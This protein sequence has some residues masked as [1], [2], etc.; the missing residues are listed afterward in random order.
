MDLSFEKFDQE[1]HYETVCDWW[2]AHKWP[3]VRPDVLSD[4]GIVITS[5]GAP[6][7]A[8]W[9][10]RSNSSVCWL[11]FFVVNPKIEKN[12]RDVCLDLMIVV[13]IERAR[14][15]GA[16][17]IFCSIKIPKLIKRLTKNGFEETDKTM[18]NMIRIL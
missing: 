15:V 10:Y 18:T 9:L 14:F 1:K 2:T 12:L 7:S 4:D 11:E 6:V 17:C 16:S 3:P 13:A 5:N 8:C